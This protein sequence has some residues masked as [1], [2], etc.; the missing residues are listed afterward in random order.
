MSLP[1]RQSARAWILVL[2]GVFGFLVWAG[3]VRMQRVDFVTNTDRDEA[4]V[5]A[6][7]PTGYAGGKRWLIVPE[8]NNRSYQWIAETQQMLARSEWRVRQIEY[9]NAPFGRAVHS[10]SPYRWWLGLVAWCDHSLSGRPLG[11]SVERAALWGN[12]LL[13]LLLLVGTTVF[14]ARQFGPFAAIILALGLVT[15][16]PFAGGFLPGVPGDHS[17]SWIFALWS[18]LPLLASVGDIERATVAK[19]KEDASSTTSPRQRTQRLFITAGIAGGLGLW[20]SAAHQTLVL[21]GIALGGIMAAWISSLRP[22]NQPANLQENAPWRAWALSGAITCLTAYLIEYFPSHLDLRLQVN[23]PLYGLAWLGA[24][25]LLVLMDSWLKKGRT[26]W[27]G[28]QFS[29][30]GCA[31][32]AVAALPVTIFTSSAQGLFGGDQ[33][34]SHLTHLPNGVV[35]KSF[36]AWLSRD[37]PTAPVVAT[38]LPLLF[39]APALWLLARRQTSVGLR[40]A[41]ALALGPVAVALVVAFSQL[42][43]WN[44]LDAMLLALAVVLTTSRQPEIKPP[45][46]RWLWAGIVTTVFLAGLI[47]LVPPSAAAGKIEFTRF[48]VEGL[49]ERSMAHWLVDHAGPGGA[50]VLLPPDRTTSWCFHGGAGL[51]GIGTANWENHDGLAATVRLVTATTAEE[52]QAQI[53][54]RGITHIILPSWDTDLDAFVRWT[55]RNPNDAFVMALHHWALPVWLRPLPYRMPTVAGFEGQS[56][57]IIEINEETNKAAALSRLAEYFVESQQLDLAAAAG[58]KLQ[59]YPA[60]LGALVAL[61]EVE[62]ARGDTPAFA[63]ILETLAASLAGGADRSLPWDRR[64]SLAIVLAQGER[65]D[66][67]REQV[68]RCLDKIDEPRIRMLTTGALFRLQMLGKAYALPIVDPKLREL[69]AKLVPAELRQRL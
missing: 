68:R 44:V 4:V 63:K 45:L 3:Y 67:A 21:V 57:A 17:L 5:D 51:R 47:Q 38:C 32:A 46:N 10:A 16:F 41:I 66:L 23:H 37:G 58:Q 56:A 53:A 18:V 20:I 15:I 25:E 35:A 11:L 54:E 43:W 1:S 40:P 6:T 55:L 28:R 12:P 61:A 14:V 13:H 26:F 7:S 30:L 31:V 24:G 29:I 36:L 42:A 27:T 19:G 2:L 52:A 50:V 22:K 62:R 48:E 49:L 34:A 65:S 9:E 8:H 69:A 39:L 59:Q 33:L 60:D 64:V